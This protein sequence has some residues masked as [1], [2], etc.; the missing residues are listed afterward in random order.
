MR[1]RFV[2]L[3]RDGTLIHERHYLSA[4]DQVELLPGVVEG[5]R[6][7]RDMGLGLVVLTNQS[8]I[9]RGIVDAF[10]LAEIHDRLRYLLGEWGL[11][12]DGIYHCPH[13]PIDACS[14]RKPHAG[15]A[16]QAAQDLGFVLSEAF[17]VGDKRID[18]QMG[19]N[20]GARTILLLT[21]YGRQEMES[22]N[23]EAD[24]VLESMGAVPETIGQYLTAKVNT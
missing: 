17:M 22:G 4:P 2:M 9:G 6:G 20:V 21:G 5:L 24:H 13:V 16:V 14:C 15:M 11:T 8:V 10:T 18:M 19:R 23:I 3:D 1:R 7:L 12:L